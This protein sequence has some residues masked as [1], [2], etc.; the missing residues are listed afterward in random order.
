MNKRTFTFTFTGEQLKLVE[1][2]VRKKLLSLLQVG[3]PTSLLS[4]RALLDNDFANIAVSLILASLINL[5]FQHEMKVHLR[6][7]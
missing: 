4:V 5:K 2:F 6:F 1:I 3:Y 7:V